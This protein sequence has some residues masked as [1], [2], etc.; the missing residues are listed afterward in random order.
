MQTVSV[1][2]YAFAYRS[3]R[4]IDTEI[5]TNRY[6]Y[7]FY[8]YMIVNFKDFIRTFNFLFLVFKFIECNLIRIEDI[9]SLI[10]NL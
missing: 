7:N 2:V 9:L 4:D 3:S 8:R 10:Y 6:Q 1:I 5:E